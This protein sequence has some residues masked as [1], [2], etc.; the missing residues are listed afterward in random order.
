MP[1]YE[2]RCTP[3]NHS[4]TRFNIRIERADKQKCDRCH[5]PM[6][7]MVSEA[8]FKVVGGTPRGNKR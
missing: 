3:C 5:Q 1:Q 6:Q 7:R 8:N 4:E 2:F